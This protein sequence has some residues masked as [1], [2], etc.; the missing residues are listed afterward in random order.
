MWYNLLGYMIEIY[1][2]TYIYF[3]YIS[4]W[5]I[6]THTHIFQI[7]IGIVANSTLK[8]IGFTMPGVFIIF[9]LWWNGMHPKEEIKRRYSGLHGQIK[10]KSNTLSLQDIK[11]NQYNF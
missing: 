2:H 1:T 8:E 6:H 11:F 10:V 9:E 3:I 4:D 5:D 7:G